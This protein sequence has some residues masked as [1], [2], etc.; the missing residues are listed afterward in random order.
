MRLLLR[1]GLENQSPRNFGRPVAIAEFQ[2]VLANCRFADAYTRHLVE[3]HKA[4]RHGAHVLHGDAG[5][6]AVQI[7]Q[8]SV[9]EVPF[10][11]GHQHRLATN[12][13][14]P[15]RPAAALSYT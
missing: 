2:G 13:G 11:H 6:L 3:T 10:E 12:K 9:G 1:G 5:N 7:E 14:N 15:V 8:V 4:P